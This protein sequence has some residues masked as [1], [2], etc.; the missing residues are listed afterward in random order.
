MYRRVLVPLDGS[1]RAEHAVPTAARIA[2]ASEGTV[3]LVEVANI[4]LGEF[5]PSQDAAA[6]G[7]VTGDRTTQEVDAYLKQVASSATLSEIATE[8][9]VLSGPVAARLLAAAQSKQADLIVLSSH[10]RTGFSRWV[11][12]SVA[13]KVARHAPVPVLVLRDAGPVP[14]GPQPGTERPL[15]VLVP[16]DGSPVAEEALVPAAALAM[17]L[18]APTQGALHLVHVV[19]EASVGGAWGGL[20]RTGQLAPFG[21]VPPPHAVETPDVVAREAVLN[22]ARSYLERVTERVHRERLGALGDRTPDITW[23]VTF[24]VDAAEAIVRTAEAGQELP[25]GRVDA[26]D[27][28]AMA[29]HG[30]GGLDRWALGSVT[31]RVLHSTALPVLIVRPKTVPADQLV[32]GELAAA[33]AGPPAGPSAPTAPL[34]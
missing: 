31:E 25:G 6:G 10:G 12:G 5:R 28:I 1:A 17:S 20:G 2:R 23:S 32:P 13:E 7:P 8:T 30:R 21:S 29:T 9:V 26:S 11:L 22:E 3:V 19:T 16:L 33:E 24:G 15:R 14:L 18:A 27:V 4:P 34:G